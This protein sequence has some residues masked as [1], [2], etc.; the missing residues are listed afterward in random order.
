[1]KTKSLF[2]ALMAI[3]LM[4]CEP[5]E[6]SMPDADTDT[7]LYAPRIWATRTANAAEIRI[8]AFPGDAVYRPYTIATPDE[9]EVYQSIG[10]PDDFKLLANL[11]NDE[12]YQFTATTLATGTPYYFYLKSKKGGLETL[13]SN[14][15]MVVPATAEN[16]VRITT[17]QG[18]PIES[19]SIS[20]NHDRLAYV[21]TAYTWDNDMYG[22]PSLFFYDLIT[23]ESSLV[24]R[25]AVFPDWS[26]TGDKLVF[27]TDQ[28][29]VGT[30]GYRPQQLALLDIA[31][32]LITRLTGGQVFNLNPAFSQ[33]GEWIAYAS[34]EGHQNEFDIWKIKA[35]GSLKTRLTNGL[36]HDMYAGNMGLGRPCWSPDGYS[37]YYG[38]LSN[39]PERDGIFRIDLPT[40]SIEPV[41][42][43]Q[44]DETGPSISPDGK[45]M[46]FF[47]DRSGLSELWLY[48]LENDAYRQLTGTTEVWEDNNWGKIEWLDNETL[49]FVAYPGDGSGHDAVYR[50]GI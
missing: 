30:V 47:S 1:M 38:V 22:A 7:R 10:G 19:A 13:S 31:S 6:D 28:G 41:L 2:I 11:Q 16:P 4:G 37:V 39:S 17:S 45:R 5:Q 3:G 27:C 14:T 9:F 44:W 18:F 26:P 21:N 15:I 29:E 32:G 36:G 34:D 50:M 48:D 35:D 43:S 49:L 23:N 33:D 8:Q 46:A 24:Q 25:E 20:P 40:G 12:T 42:Q